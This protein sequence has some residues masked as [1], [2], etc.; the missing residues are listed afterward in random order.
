M[1]RVIITGLSIILFLISICCQEEPD[2][3]KYPLVYDV[4]VDKTNVRTGDEI[5]VSFYITTSDFPDSWSQYY[6]K[7]GKLVTN[8][9]DT[10]DSAIIYFIRHIQEEDIVCEKKGEHEEWILRDGVRT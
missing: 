1:K 5:T 6:L 7:D 10:G 9:S 4:T 8:E 3:M 2:G